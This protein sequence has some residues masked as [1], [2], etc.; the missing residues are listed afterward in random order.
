M[1][2]GIIREA[3][4]K[5]ANEILNLHRRSVHALCCSHYT[6]SEIDAWT[7]GKRADQYIAAM[8]SN[9][10]MCVAE[11][12]QTK[13]IT[14]FAAIEISQEQI[15][16]VY[17]DPDFVGRGIARS[18]LTHLEDLALAAGLTQLSLDSSLNAESF[19]LKSGYSVIARSKSVLRQEL[20]LKSVSM[21]KYLK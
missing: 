5:D 9:E 18:L 10:K 15:K 21:N 6:D 13:R 3:Q 14:G 8:Q 2:R 12:R 20:L 1:Y 4:A 7:S 16:A 17:V 11:E 19:Y